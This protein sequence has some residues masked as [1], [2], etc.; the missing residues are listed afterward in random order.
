[1]RLFSPIKPKSELATYKDQTRQFSSFI[2]L[3]N[4]HQFQ[5]RMIP[6]R[7]LCKCL[8]WNWGHQ[9]SQQNESSSEVLNIL[10]PAKSPTTVEHIDLPP[11]SSSAPTSIE[12]VYLQPTKLFSMEIILKLFLL[13]TQKRNNDEGT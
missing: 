9:Q 5:R 3:T 4:A 11:I 10:S 13:G 12:Q 2:K 7:N 1:M 8:C 6:T